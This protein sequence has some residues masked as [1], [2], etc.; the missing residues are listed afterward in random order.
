MSILGRARGRFKAGLEQSI[1]QNRRRWLVRQLA[2]FARFYDQAWEFPGFEL[3]KNG[4][5]ALLSALQS[6]PIATIFDVG[7]NVGDWST[8]AASTFPAAKIHAFE[9]VPP[10]FKHLQDRLATV[11]NTSLHPYGLGKENKRTEITYYGDDLSFLSTVNYAIQTHLPSTQM[12]IEIRRGDDILKETNVTKIDFLKLDIEGMEIE[13]LYG[14]EQALKEQRIGFIQF[15][16]HPGQVLLKNFYDLLARHGFRLGKMYA[17]YV[18]FSEYHV[19]FERYAGPNYFASPSTRSDL[20]ARL[21]KG[22]R[23]R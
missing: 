11:S 6:E 9:P 12:P 16:H 1:R 5:G 20:I 7:A 13:A 15:E 2:R 19:S 8:L 4:E 22:Y 14:F 23:H 10:T 17:D 18:D 3:T 21:S